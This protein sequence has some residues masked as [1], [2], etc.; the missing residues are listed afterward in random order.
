MENNY[1]FKKQTIN[2]YGAKLLKEKII[3]KKS[4]LAIQNTM[5]HTEV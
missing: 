5:N 4:L 1:I 2:L 3:E